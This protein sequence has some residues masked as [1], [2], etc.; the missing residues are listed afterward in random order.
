MTLEPGV[1]VDDAGDGGSSTEIPGPGRQASAG[2]P[3]KG[4]SIGEGAWVWDD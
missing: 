4:G 1:D 3:Q 2:R